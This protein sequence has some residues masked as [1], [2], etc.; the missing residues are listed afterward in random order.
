MFLG[1]PNDTEQS[2]TAPVSIPLKEIG[3]QGC[4]Y[5]MNVYVIHH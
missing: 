2:K 3:I 5:N 1:Q 4:N